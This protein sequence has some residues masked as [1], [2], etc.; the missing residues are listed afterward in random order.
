MKEWPRRGLRGK[1]EQSR[2]SGIT[3]VAASPMKEPT[4]T[5]HT[6][7]KKLLFLG[8]DVHAQSIA[9]ALA[10]G[11]GAEAR[12]Y[13]S[14]ANDL[15]ALEKVFETNATSRA[16]SCEGNFTAFSASI[17]RR[18]PACRPPPSASC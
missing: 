10:E 1:A 13:G 17:S 11:G 8:L 16:S 14:I 12:T 18:C 3:A 5:K 2:K 7:S 4:H 6:M 9:I 15:H